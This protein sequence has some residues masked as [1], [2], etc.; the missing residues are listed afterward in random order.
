MANSK[1]ALVSLL[2]LA[3]INM[4]INME[5]FCGTPQKYLACRIVILFYSSF[6]TM[7]NV[8]RVGLELL[9]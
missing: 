3:V 4:E 7:S 5:S 6:K 8:A 9:M 2:P 1:V